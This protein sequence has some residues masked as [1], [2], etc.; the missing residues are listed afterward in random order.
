M[1]LTP[2]NYYSPRANR[3]YMSVSQF[4]DFLRCE[5]Y[6]L[7]KV[8]G[9]VKEEPSTAMLIGSYVDAYFSGEM[10]VF[11]AEHPE[12][13]KRDGTLKAE[14]AHA[15]YII[16]RIEAQPAMMRYFTGEHQR[17][18]TCSIA[19]VPFKVKIDTYKPGKAIVDGKVM[20]DFAPQYIEEQGR[21]PWYQAWKYDLQGAVYQEAV[22]QN[23]GKKLPFILNAAT[24]E[25]EPDLLLMQISQPELDYELQV[26]IEN[27]P[28][29]DAIKKGF[30]KPEPCGE[31]PYCK[32]HKKVKLLKS[33]DIYDA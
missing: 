11:K 22:F 17:I 21:V 13:F 6:A 19:G 28:R 5:A 20:K 2:K 9:R 7:A 23:T 3:E 15:D 10:D 31:C 25:P 27:A 16:S 4:K 24:K 8:R 33:E 14:F 1:N 29:F 30:I 32:K 18:F 12:I 26:V